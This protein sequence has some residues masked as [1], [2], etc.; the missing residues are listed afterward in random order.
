MLINAP[1]SAPKLATKRV[2]LITDNDDPFA[3]SQNPR[4]ITSAR[5]T[6]V[7]SE[8]IPQIGNLCLL[9]FA[10]DLLQAGV[11]VEPFFISADDKPF[12]QHKFWTVRTLFAFESFNSERL[13][14]S[15]S[16]TRRGT[17]ML[18]FYL[19]KSPSLVSMIYLIRCDSTRS[20]NEPS[21]ASRSSLQQDLLLVS[22]A[23]ISSRNRKRG[24]ISTSWTWEI[25]W[26]L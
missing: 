26:R 14:A 11:S 5:T 6:L 3:G 18:T 22:R 4:L 10:K 21:S 2:F 8:N 25:K 9:R 13:R 7:V 24:H 12:N 23:I 16:Q 1:S 19:L 17:R 20:R 15:L